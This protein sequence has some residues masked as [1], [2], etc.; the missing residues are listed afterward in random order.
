MST[1]SRVIKV[2]SVS[3]VSN[4]KNG[5]PFKSIGFASIGLIYKDLGDGKLIPVR[6]K[7]RTT[8]VNISGESYLDG[9]PEFGY[10]L[11]VG[12]FVEG[13]I[14]TKAVKPYMIPQGEG[15]SR[16]VSTYTTAVFG[17]P[18]ADN[19][20]NLIKVTFKNKQHEIVE[21]ITNFPLAS[22]VSVTKQEE[23]F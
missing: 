23:V 10:D 17:D 20:E 15:L 4:D 19:W 8:T 18:T 21:L 7:S 2:V 13:D 14:V 5:R 6:T 3:Q 11:E 9:K 1:N 12:D 16:E 22:P